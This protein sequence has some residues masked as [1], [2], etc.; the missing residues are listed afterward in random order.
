MN[1]VIVTGASEGLGFELSKLFLEKDISVTGI[2]RTRPN[3]K[4]DFIKTDLTVEEDI[5]NAASMILKR[6]FR[7]RC[8]NQ[9]RWCFKCN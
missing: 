8:D 3:L 5:E 9:L 7:L 6:L 2:S 4:V 1:R